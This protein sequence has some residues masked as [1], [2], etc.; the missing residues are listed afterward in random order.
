MSLGVV[1]RITILGVEFSILLFTSRHQ[2]GSLPLVSSSAYLD[3]GV[4]P[5]A[6]SWVLYIV[7]IRYQTHQR[8]EGW[9]GV[10]YEYEVGRCMKKKFKKD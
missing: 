10:I 8:S 6:S 7:H 9:E 1:Q 2:I 3:Q 5:T 4:I